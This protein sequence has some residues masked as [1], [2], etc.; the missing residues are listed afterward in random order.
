MPEYIYDSLKIL[1]GLSE[2]AQ[3][4]LYDQKEMMSSISWLKDFCTIRVASARTT[5]HSESITRLLCS[6][7]NVFCIFPN[8]QLEKR[9]I[10]KY[11]ELFEE[12]AK[13][14][15]A[16]AYNCMGKIEGSCVFNNICQSLRGKSFDQI[17]AIIVD[18]SYLLS[19]ENENLIYE[20]L[21]GKEL[22]SPFFIIFLQ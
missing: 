10:N 8:K 12:A 13:D 20:M 6:G 21:V 3:N 5:G 15:L 9:I 16:Y 19:K 1:M 22:D 4:D 14:D 7:L 2:R 17:D 11:S 18:N